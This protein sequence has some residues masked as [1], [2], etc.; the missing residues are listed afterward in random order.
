M[1]AKLEDWVLHRN[2]VCPEECG[3][4]LQ[5]EFV[6][7]RRRSSRG[8]HGVDDTRASLLNEHIKI[9]KA[10]GRDQKE[11]ESSRDTR[12]VVVETP[13]SIE[14]SWGR[15]QSGMI[16]ERSDHVWQYGH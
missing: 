14:P 15:E 8:D 16:P 13:D 11:T 2:E 1:N 3:K 4:Q 7:L 12:I 6:H 9:N 10:W 5:Q